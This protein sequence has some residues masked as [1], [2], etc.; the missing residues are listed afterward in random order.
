MPK[1]VAEMGPAQVRNLRHGFVQ[2]G[3][4]S[5]KSKPGDPCVAYHRVGGVDGL[6]LQCRPPRDGQ[7][8]GSRSWVLITMVGSRRREIGLGSFPDVSLAEARELARKEKAD[9]RNGID[10]VEKRRRERAELIEAQRKQITFKEIAEEYYEIEVATYGGKDPKRQKNR[11]K[12]SI[13]RSNEEIGDIQIGE[14]DVQDVLR[15]LKNYWYTQT[16]TATRL[17][18]TIAQIWRMA[19]SR[20]LVSGKNPAD[21]V[22]NLDGWLPSAKSIHKK[23]RKPA[24]RYQDIPDFMKLLQK[25]DTTPARALE[26]QI[27]TAARPTEVQFAEWSEIDFEERVW[28]TPGTKIKNRDDDK[29]HAVP[30]TPRAIEILEMM[31]RTGQYVF[32]GYRGKEQFSENALN[33][34]VKAIHAAS[35]AEGGKGFIDPEYKKIACAHGMRRVFKNFSSSKTNFDDV[36]SELCLS[37]LDSDDTRSAYLSDQILDRRRALLTMYERYIYT[38]KLPKKRRASDYW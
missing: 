9:I 12:K 33:D 34:T 21:W 38:G 32:Q 13:K 2:E 11:L 17:R 27:L 28:T 24:M 19:E 26:F 4:K 23:K 15:V 8:I 36:V 25:R 10:P 20:K 1:K 7:E 29:P 5:T 30:L 31:P 16:P 6:A 3:S 18:Q 22:D 14:L 37:H 35:I